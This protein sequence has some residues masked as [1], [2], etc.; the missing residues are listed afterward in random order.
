MEA[1]RPGIRFWCFFAEL[2]A[3]LREQRM[4]RDLSGVSHPA[5]ES[6]HSAK[7]FHLNPISQTYE[8]WHAGRAGSNQQGAVLQRTGGAELAAIPQFEQV[9]RLRPNGRREGR[10]GCLA[11]AIHGKKSGVLQVGM[12]EAG[13]RPRPEHI[14]DRK[15]RKAK[16]SR[17]CTAKKKWYLLEPALHILQERRDGRREFPRSLTSKVDQLFRY[18]F[19]YSSFRRQS[20]ECHQSR[21]GEAIHGAQGNQFVDV[22]WKKVAC[23][24][25]RERARGAKIIRMLQNPG[26]LSGSFRRFVERQSGA[27]SGLAKVVADSCA[28][29]GSAKSHGRPVPGGT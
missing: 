10:R 24:H 20:R 13:H 26:D 8:L 2:Q 23:L 4:V 16:K 29:F 28:S 7:H 9:Q 3:N 17:K 15:I 18:L 12:R 6:G 21:H 25:V 5:D 22:A 1:R 11:F 14:P 19:P 27:N